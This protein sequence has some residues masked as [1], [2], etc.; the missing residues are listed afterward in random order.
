MRMLQTPEH[1]TRTYTLALT[2]YETRKQSCATIT[3]NIGSELLHTTVFFPRM[4]VSRPLGNIQYL[5]RIVTVCATYRI[6]H[7]C[8]LTYVYARAH[9]HL[10]NY[11]L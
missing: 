2:Q 6:A 8:M 1:H 7:A 5:Y 9:T 4:T 10:I 11:K 3:Q